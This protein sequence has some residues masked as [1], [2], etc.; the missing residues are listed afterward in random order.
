MSVRSTEFIDDAIR[1]S[2]TNDLE[3]KSFGWG[4]GQIADMMAWYDKLDADPTKIGGR[5]ITVTGYSLGGHLATAFNVVMVDRKQGWRID[6]TYTFNGAGIG[7]IKAGHTITDALNE[8]NAAKSSGA[9]LNYFQDSV[10]KQLYIDAKALLDANAPTAA[11]IS[12]VKDLIKNTFPL[13]AIPGTA[14]SDAH[15]RELNL[16]QDAIK[17]VEDV[18]KEAE[19]VNGGISSGVSGSLPALPTPKQNIAQLQLDYQL[20]VGRASQYTNSY[21]SGVF[22]GAVKA[23]DPDRALRT[24]QGAS[25]I[26]DIYGAPLPSAVAN[27]QIHIGQSKPIYIEDQPLTRGSYV[28][29]AWDSSSLLRGET[30]LLNNGFAKNDFGDT[31]SLVLMVDSLSVQAMLAKLDPDVDSGT[32]NNLLK[33]ATNKWRVTDADQGKAEADVLE[34][35]LNSLGKMF[36]SGWTD[37]KANPSGGSWFVIEDSGSYTGRET[38]H[39]KLAEIDKAITARGLA[40]KVKVT[41]SNIDNG[42]LARDDFGALL[43]LENFSP[44]LL[45]AKNPADR[46]W[47]AT[48]LEPANPV[49][50]AA[51][52]ADKDMSYQDKEA[53]KQTYTDAYLRAR[54]EMLNWKVQFNEKNVAYDATFGS[55]Q[56]KLPLPDPVTVKTG[57]M[58]IDSDYVYKDNETKITLNIDGNTSDKRYITFGADTAETLT[59]AAFKDRLFGGQGNDTLEGQGGNDYLEGNAGVDKL[60]GGADNDIL[61]GGIGDDELTGG[62]GND[63]LKGGDGTDT[64]KFDLNAGFGHDNIIEADGLGKLDVAGIGILDGKNAKAVVGQKDTWR[65]D[66]DKVTYTQVELDS[67]STGYKTGLLITFK[68][69]AKDSIRIDGWST[70]KNVGIVFDTAPV[71]PPVYNPNFNPYQGDFIKKTKPGTIAG[72]G[73]QYVTGIGGYVSNGAQAD[74]PDWIGGSHDADN[75]QGLGGNDALTG[76]RGDDLLDGGAGDDLMTGGLGADT[77]IGGAGRDYLFGSAK[78]WSFGPEYTNDVFYSPPPANATDVSTG[79]GWVAYRQPVSGGQSNRGSMQV[80]AGVYSGLSADPVLA[81]DAGNVIDGG[82]G[83]DYIVG[84]TGNDTVHG[85]I[86]N[87]QIFG[88]DLQDVLFGD[89]GNDQIRGDG[90]SHPVSIPGATGYTLGLTY[91]PESLHGG[92]I[93]SGGKGN[94]SLWGQGQDDQLYG[95]DDDDQLWG[96]DEPAYV[97]QDVPYAIQGNDTLEGGAGKDQLVGGGRDDVLLGGSGNDSLWGDGNLQGPQ[98]EEAYAA[99]THGKDILDGEEGDDYLEGGG[100]DDTLVGGVGKDRLLGDASQAGLKAGESGKDWLDGGNDDDY[101]EGGGQNDTLLGGAGSD[102]LNGDGAYADANDQGDDYLD[103]GDGRDG[104]FGDGGNDVLLGGAGNDILEGGDGNDTLDGGLGTDVLRGGAGNDTYLFDDQDTVVDTVITSGTPVEAMQDNEGDNTIVLEGAYASNLSVLTPGG[105]NRSNLNIS[106]GESSQLVVLNGVAG[107]TSNT[108]VL[109]DGQELKTYE[110]VGQYASTGGGA[111]FEGQ[112]ASGNGYALGGRGVDYMGT[113]GDHATLSGGRGDDVINGAGAANTYLYAAGDGNDLIVDG[114]VNGGVL[115]VEGASTIQFGKGITL[116]DITSLQAMTTN[117]GGGLTN[118]Y[119]VVN[120]GGGSTS[121][122]PAGRISIQGFDF[123]NP[124]APL[125]TTQSAAIASGR[126][127]ANQ[128][129]F[130]QERCAA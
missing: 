3:V 16:L 117:G 124:S 10:A 81:N 8:F 17:R 13:A 110:L 99:A 95:G 12:K 64:Y 24:L 70:S 62:I 126:G 108:F 78:D 6:N 19:R 83:D 15:L 14:Q 104:L 74:A 105:A 88:L 46:D 109:G 82:A 94:D 92:D 2:K 20:A 30:R 42:G 29:D 49:V 120:I 60:D 125:T 61:L 101:L 48:Q 37:L 114:S 76:Y 25:P 36:V 21:N 39:K 4:F 130:I 44:V 57:P 121:T 55:M 43:S 86:D 53:G 40:G 66:D 80:I 90:A 31:H 51:W 7:E 85:G 27:S 119:L 34:N 50:Y 9:N 71:T 41:A 73:D 68:G 113:V 96:D 5:N 127:V 100:Q 11:Q 22:V 112:D 63:T 52:K 129:K 91:L 103:G 111:A 115:N 38:F 45:A 77:L 98:G 118:Q 107:A 67:T 58:R 93:L 32:L 59:G 123:N 122:V 18:N 75:I 65:S 87:D 97:T 69:N 116:A 54:A 28:G 35:V 26:Y 47:L 128:S 33:D 84:G 89:D 106:M 72:R 102:E 56:I 23:I 1:D 79:F